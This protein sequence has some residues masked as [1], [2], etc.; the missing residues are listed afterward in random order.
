ML[1]IARLHLMRLPNDK[2]LE[3]ILPSTRTTEAS[4][5]GPDRIFSAHKSG[6]GERGLEVMR[7]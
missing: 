1:R 4:E 6:K 7:A 5:R 2:K 3:F